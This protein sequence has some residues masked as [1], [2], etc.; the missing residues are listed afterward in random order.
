MAFNKELIVKEINRLWKGRIGH[1]NLICSPIKRFCGL[2]FVW[3][4]SPKGPNRPLERTRE[5]NIMTWSVKEVQ[6]KY[7]IFVFFLF[8]KIYVRFSFCLKL[9]YFFLLS[10]FEVLSFEASE[11]LSLEGFNSINRHPP[12]DIEL[13][14]SIGNYSVPFLASRVF[15]YR[16]W[17]NCQSKTKK[18]K[19]KKKEPLE[20]S[21]RFDKNSV[22]FSSLIAKH[23]VQAQTFKRICR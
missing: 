6:I 15:W 2:G 12:F 4:T 18:N 13:D 17:W 20:Y 14:G 8:L 22:W 23:W 21:I 19:R 5:K 16:I 3:R 10:N 9:Q 1:W 7:N 11:V